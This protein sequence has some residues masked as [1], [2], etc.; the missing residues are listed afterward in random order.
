MA[1]IVCE[2]KHSVYIIGILFNIQKIHFGLFLECTEVNYSSI[3]LIIF[4]VE[5]KI[6]KS[7]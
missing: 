2:V 7:L 5:Q 3:L 6:S 1:I 4:L